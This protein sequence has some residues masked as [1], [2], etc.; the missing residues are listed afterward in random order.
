VWSTPE[1]NPFF[2]ESFAIAHRRLKTNPPRPDEP[3]PFKLGF[4]DALRRALED[5]RFR[6]ISVVA[7]P[8]PNIFASASEALEF[9]QQALGL[10]TQLLEGLSDKDRADVWR[11]IERHLCAFERDGSFLAE[12]ELLVGSGTRQG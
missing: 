7:V 9:Q 11:E 12:G 6:D 2:S 1:R 5:A 10:L 4:D 3:G 8:A